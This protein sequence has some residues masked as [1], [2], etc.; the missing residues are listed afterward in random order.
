VTTYRQ[1]VVLFAPER[2]QLPIKPPPTFILFIN[3]FTAD[4]V[5]AQLN[6]DTSFLAD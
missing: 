6:F 5:M 3:Q 1:S 2:N 4:E